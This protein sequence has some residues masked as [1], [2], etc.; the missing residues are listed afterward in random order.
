MLE[1]A[2]CFR[3]QPR[4]YSREPGQDHRY[5]DY[6][7]SQ[8]SA[9][10]PLFRL[11]ERLMLRYAVLISFLACLAVAVHP[12]SVLGQQSSDEDDVVRVNTDLLLFPIRIRD[13]KGQAIAGLTD[14]DLT[15]KDPDQVT[16]GVYF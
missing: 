8:H 5:H 9:L 1:C 2:F 10:R 7:H 11:A 16:T 4:G 13:K 6:R 14:Q 15:L 12:T 3:S